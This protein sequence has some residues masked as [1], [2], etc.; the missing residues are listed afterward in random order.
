MP[1]K[2][3]N[4]NSRK[5]FWALILG[6]EIALLSGCVS[7]TKYKELEQRLGTSETQRIE[8]ESKINELEVI[9]SQL[10]KKLGIASDD[11]ESLQASVVQMREALAELNRRKR[12][13]EKRI[14]EYRELVRKFKALTDAG[15]LVVKI[16]GGKMVV[17]L[18][19]DVLFASGSARLSTK[20][21][22]TVAQVAKLLSQ[23]P[24]R[25]F[26][27]EGHTDNVPIKTAQFPSN[28]ELAAARAGHVVA[29]L[30]A[31]GLDPKRV[32]A[33]SFGEHS[34]ARPND[35]PEGRMANR[36]IEIVVVPD[37]SQL[38]GYDELQKFTASDSDQG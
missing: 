35:S 28:W 5:W 20:G 14:G 15:Q 27:V 25:H 12:E 38:P 29:V 34:P 19:S 18:P 4:G 31:G 30:I 1:Q 22:E 26:Q 10:E 8:R 9:I 7:K 24:E 36:R 6:F 11:K 3:S 2:L 21:E 32:S 33:A 23:I 17:G 16:V 37:L 13:S